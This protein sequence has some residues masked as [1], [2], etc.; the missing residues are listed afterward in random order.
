MRL[1]SLALILAAGLFSLWALGLDLVSAVTCLAVTPLFLF[2]PGFLIESL[3]LRTPEKTLT[4]RLASAVLLGFAICLACYF[5]SLA[6]GPSAFWLPLTAYLALTSRK[7][8]LDVLAVGTVV[9]DRLTRLGHRNLLYLLVILFSALIVPMMSSPMP[10]IYHG[11]VLC[12]SHYLVHISRVV[13]LERRFPCERVYGED[14]SEPDGYSNLVNIF[15]VVATKITGI[16][17]F[18]FAHRYYYLSVIPILAGLYALLLHRAGLRMGYFVLGMAF[19]LLGGDWCKGAHFSV[20]ML[21]YIPVP[22]GDILLLALAL[23]FMDQK[24]LETRQA[25]LLIALGGFLTAAARLNAALAILGAVVV[26]LVLRRLVLGTGVKASLPAVAAAGL[27]SAV[28]FYLFC[29]YGITK[30]LPYLEQ[31]GTPY[32][33]FSYV[34]YTCL[35]KCMLALHFFKSLT[36]PGLLASGI[37]SINAFLVWLASTAF[38]WW[39]TLPVVTRIGERIRHRKITNESLMLLSMGAAGMG[40]ASVVMAIGNEQIYFLHYFDIAWFTLFCLE[41][42]RLGLVGRSWWRLRDFGIRIW[43]NGLIALDFLEVKQARK[44]G[45]VLVALFWL[46]VACAPLIGMS[47][48]LTAFQESHWQ[49]V[50]LSS[51][52]PALS[53]VIHVAPLPGFSGETCY[54]TQPMYDA[55]SFIRTGTPKDAVV[56]A[57]SFV[58]VEGHRPYFHFLTAITERTPYLQNVWFRPESS[59]VS[60]RLAQLADVKEGIVDPSLLGRKYVFLVE[61]DLMDKLG[62]T[63]NTELLYKND[64]WSVAYITS[65]D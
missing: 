18:A 17:A 39:F 56:V 59:T 4:A 1:C 14:L 5:V 30:H 54:L 2:F 63:Y 19:V 53:K 22:M 44:L 28:G 8:R 26:Y 51:R 62:L 27:G 52:L 60:R 11:T 36:V 37:L 38:G 20:N 65:R 64:L 9:M 12:D 25:A 10:G 6:F 48:Y 45:T 16:S 33:L 13:S 43:R 24:F 42:Q 50:V 55:L 41:L 35:G 31:S 47:R 57:P 58:I 34:R 49:N 61:N 15:S 3:C 21:A 40:A 7:V 23:V 29:V 32:F 46:F